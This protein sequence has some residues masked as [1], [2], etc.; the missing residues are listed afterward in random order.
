MTTAYAIASAASWGDHLRTT[1]KLAR[2]AAIL[3]IALGT[4]L[5]RGIVRAVASAVSGGASALEQSRRHV[6]GPIVYRGFISSID[7]LAAAI[8]WG[9]TRLGGAL[10]FADRKITSL[11]A[12]LIARA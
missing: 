3:F 4:G 8:A 11:D 9:L 10:H 7:R 6:S 5:V 12:A 2:R 1:G